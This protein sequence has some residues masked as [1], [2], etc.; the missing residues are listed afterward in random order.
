MI[1]L[2]T[3]HSCPRDANGNEHKTPLDDS[4]YNL[5]SNNE[6][7]FETGTRLLYWLH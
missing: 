5:I 7:V 2:Y 1:K 4:K 3:T 6:F